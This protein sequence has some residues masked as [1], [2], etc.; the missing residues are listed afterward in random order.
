[1]VP[2]KKDYKEY[3]NYEDIGKKHFFFLEKQK[4]WGSRIAEFVSLG[5]SLTHV[6]M[7]KKKGCDWDYNKFKMYT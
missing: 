3:G 4:P 1:M 6:N 5:G 2:P 7:F